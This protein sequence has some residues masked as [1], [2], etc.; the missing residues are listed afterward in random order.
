[1]FC[2]SEREL[3]LYNSLVEARG[4][5]DDFQKYYLNLAVWCYCNH[6]EEYKKV[7]TKFIE[8]EIKETEKLNI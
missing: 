7:I 6:P 1:M 3:E 8:D 4:T 2:E 5:M